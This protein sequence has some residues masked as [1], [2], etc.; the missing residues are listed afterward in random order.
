MSSYTGLYVQRYEDGTIHGVQVADPFGNS[1]SL[2]PQ[3]YIDREVKP[4]IE[5]LPDQANYQS[6]P[7]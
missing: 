7:A 4:P 3:D 5:L 6:K 2:D 1:L